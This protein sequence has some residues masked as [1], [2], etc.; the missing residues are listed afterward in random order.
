MGLGGGHI[1][2]LHN[3]NMKIEKIILKTRCLF[4]LKFIS[5]SSFICAE[6]AK[7]CKNVFVLILSFG[8]YGGQATSGHVLTL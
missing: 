1:Y 5:Y 7:I 8:K 3:T 6:D 4:F 2:C